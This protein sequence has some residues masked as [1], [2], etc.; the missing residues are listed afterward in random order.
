MF[1]SELPSRERASETTDERAAQ[2]QLV[3]KNLIVSKQLIPP[4]SI[5]L[6]RGLT[7]KYM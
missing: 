3:R 2:L 4:L 6:G 5:G 1:G 7:Q